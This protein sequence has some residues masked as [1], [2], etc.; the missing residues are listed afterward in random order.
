MSMKC[1]SSVCQL[2]VCQ[3]SY[4]LK[5]PHTTFYDARMHQCKNFSNVSFTVIFCRKCSRHLTFEEFFQQ[6][7]HPLLLSAISAAPRTD[8]RRLPSGRRAGDL[9]SCV[10][11]RARWVVWMYVGCVCF[12]LCVC[13]R[14]SVCV[15]VCLS[16]CGCVRV[17]VFFFL[18]VVLV[19]V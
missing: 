3:R 6:Q 15:C 12:P 4:K 5:P 17:R 9:R 18:V 10:C 7:Q 19:C 11:A 13:E 16:V 2:S 14:V 1:K 8:G